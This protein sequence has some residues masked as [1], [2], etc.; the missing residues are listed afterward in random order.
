M[1]IRFR[2]KWTRQR[3]WDAPWK[4]RLMAATMPACWSEMTSCTPSSPR[5][6]SLR[7]NSR[8]KTSFSESPTS[9]PR[10]SLCPVADTPVA[11]TTALEVTWWFSRTWR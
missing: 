9:M 3:W 4:H 1:A 11:M 8:Q 6:R 2:A 7:R 5:A 10:I